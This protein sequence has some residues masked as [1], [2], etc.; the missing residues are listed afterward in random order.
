MARKRKTPFKTREEWLVAFTKR[1]RV[2]FKKHGYEIPENVRMAVGFTSTGARGKRIGECWTDEASEDGAFEIF[3]DPK[4]GDPSRVADVLTHELIHAT[5]GIEAGHK[6]P[7]VDCMNAVGLVGKPTATVAGVDWH[8]WADPILS[9]LGPLPHAAIKPGN[10]KKKQ[11]TRM[12]KCECVNCGFT[13][14]TSAKWLEN[15]E[16]LRCPDT[17]CRGMLAIG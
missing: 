8:K 15:G 1:A 10:G 11:T 5:V 6:K 4:L 9:D 3:I 16:D 14:R 7:F 2:E 12:I 13:F 17:Y